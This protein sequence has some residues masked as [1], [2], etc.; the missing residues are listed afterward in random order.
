MHVLWDQS[1]DMEVQEV[2]T[3][4]R[5]FSEEEEVHSGEKSHQEEELKDR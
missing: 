2:L 1:V 5:L 4:Q 3:R